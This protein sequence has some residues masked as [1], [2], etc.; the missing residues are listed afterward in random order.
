MGYRHGRAGV[1]AVPHPQERRAFLY[2]PLLALLIT[3]V[4]EL[5]NHKAF[6][7][8]L[9]SFLRF[10]TGEPL[11]LL[12]NVLIVLASFS[13]AFFLRRRVFWCALVSFLWLACGAVNGFILLN[14]MTPF[15]VADLTIFQTGISTVPNYLSTGYIILLIS[16]LALV[17]VGL[18]LLFWKGPR[19][20]QP[21]RARLLAGAAAAAVSGLL[22]GGCCALAFAVGDL[23]HQFANLAYA[24]EDYGFSYCFLQTWLNRG[25]RRPSGYSQAA[26]EKICKTAEEGTAGNAAQAQ[27]D[28][29]VVFIQLESFI[30]PSLIRG[31]ELSEDPVPNWTAM[32]AQYSSGYLTVPVVGAGTANTEFEVLTGMSTRFFGPG[33]YPYQTC[34]TDE[35][36]ESVAYDLKE[37]GYAAHAIHNHQASFYS[38][39]EVYPN[40]GFDDF[41]ALEYMPQ[42]EKTP[43]NWATDGI[44]KEE[45]LQALDVTEDQA[46]LVFTVTVQSHGKYPADPVLEDPAVTVETCPDEDYRYA[47][48]YYVNQLHEVDA[49]LGELT[50]EL[51]AR[52]ERTVLVLYGDHLPA[53]DL[54]AADLE[55]G[56]LYRTEYILWDNFGLE[57]QDENLAAYQLSAAVL[58]R[59]GIT[60]GLMNSFH[61]TYRARPDYWQS[62]RLLE[63]DA[64]YGAGYQYGERGRYQ[65]AEMEMGMVP[66]VITGM[67]PQGENWLIL[68]ENFTP[69][70]VVTENGARRE[71]EYVSPKLLRVTEAL[72]TTDYRDLEILV[73]DRH[74]EVLS[75]TE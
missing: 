23:S 36:V 29:N 12:T 11:A 20:S 56:S 30:D 43:T 40:L 5:F 49:F 74:N 13:P 73:V 3:I 7:E 72:D 44:L 34:L 38:R 24:Y 58:A 67:R 2:L 27:P 63:Y 18:A 54:K 31:L 16:A 47:I 15:T 21:P 46:D 62:L 25:I 39:N 66:I 42:V 51:A 52:E 70:C 22:L 61:Q 41:T 9:A 4:V 55:S 37:N 1:D 53:L 48:E 60:T 14:R 65:P 35:A 28:V 32:K 6:T 59:F 68:G 17:A 8:G 45:I 26:V 50:A 75:G 19:S 10:V 69:Y 71:T 57:Q 64:L 33:E